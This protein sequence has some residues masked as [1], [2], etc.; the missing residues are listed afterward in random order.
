MS[1][2][3]KSLDESPSK[4]TPTGVAPYRVFPLVIAVV[5][6]WMIYAALTLLQI[7]M[8]T[9]FLG[10]L[11]AM[12]ILTL[13][14]LGWWLSR[15]KIHWLERVSIL[16]LMIVG[17]IAA[18][19]LLHRSVLA[20]SVL[21]LAL[22]AVITASTIWLWIC[23]GLTAGTRRLGLVA[24][25]LAI[26]ASMTLVR[27]EGL[28]GAG[29]PE[30]RW[31]WSTSREEEF[32]A[33]N[34]S[35][36]TSAAAATGPV[37]S[38]SKDWPGFRGPDR[39]GRV[40]GVKIAT[41]WKTSPPKLLWRKRVGPAWSSMVIVG[42]RLF[43]QEQRGATEVVVC[44]DANTGNENWVHEDAGRFEENMGGVG[45]RA[46]PTFADGKIYSLGAAG[47]LNCL[48]AATGKPQWSRNI[49]TDS[50][51]TVPMWG[52]SSS[53]LVASGLV[54]VYAGGTG[55]HGLLAYRADSGEPQWQVPT[56]QQSYSS[57]QL[58]TLNGQEQILFVCDKALTSVDPS[59]GDVLWSYVRE[60]G[61]GQPA[62]QPQVVSDSQLLVSFAPDSGTALLEVTRDAK[63]WHAKP[64]W[65]SRNLKPFFNDFVRY[66]DALFGF[67]GNI[68]CCVD[69]KTGK[70]NWKGGRYGNGEVLLIADQSL[71]L[72]IS[73][74]GDAVLVEANPKEHRELGRIHAIDGKTWNHPVISMDRMF[75]RNAE[76]MA[77]YELKPL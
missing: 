35:K 58:V 54:I 15:R 38:S 59:T 3:T 52:F 18:T 72:V 2:L 46:T 27:M 25:P 60:E 1:T 51:A 20:P 32:L 70:R 22:P 50:G 13:F 16:G 64:K 43:T 17:A 28:T 7:S 24:I 29:Q 23:R 53:P 12:A 63:A 8:F 62:V 11:A 5:L 76:E 57:P 67:D 39:D 19:L 42:D 55:D 74:S 21:L 45:P 30:F 41:D 36:S 56:G 47:T 26:W 71:L 49:V 10:Q 4:A 68:F 66:G 34:S 61:M 44:V 77:C 33:S 48:D 37:V 6:Y 40:H 75:V 65:K 73:E 69:L 14:F 31:R 9:R